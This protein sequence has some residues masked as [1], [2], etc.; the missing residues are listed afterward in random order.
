MR[1]AVLSDIHG[2]LHA[3]DAVLEEVEREDVHAVWCLGDVVDASPMG[4]DGRA[5]LWLYAWGS[6]ERRR[7]ASLVSA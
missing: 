7:S 5:A 1:I 4:E 6:I 2:N 3:L